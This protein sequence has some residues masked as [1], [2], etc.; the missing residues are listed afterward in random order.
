MIL[1][2]LEN[3]ILLHHIRGK[4]I[5]KILTEDDLIKSEECGDQLYYKEVSL[6]SRRKPPNLK[7][8]KEAQAKTME[9][10]Y[11]LILS[12][13]AMCEEE[14]NFQIKRRNKSVILKN[15]M[16]MSRWCGVL[17]KLRRVTSSVQL[18]TGDIRMCNG[19]KRGY[20]IISTGGNFNP[21]EIG[22]DVNSRPLAIKRIPKSSNIC[23]SLK[24]LIGPLLG[25]RNTHILQYFAC[26]YK[27]SEL[28]LATPLCEYNISEY[29][30][31]M[32]H[33][34]R[35]PFLSSNTV[36]SQFLSGLRFLHEFKEPIVHG[37]LKPSNIFIDLR[38]NVRIAEF[39]IYKV[40]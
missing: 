14:E 20:Y 17:E 8:Q 1:N 7:L 33:N 22:L 36:A 12:I 23:R 21:V 29:M 24:L 27:E 38:G 3:C 25:V 18:Q 2:Q 34:T 13:A 11:H 4:A 19:E 32:R 30:V 15:A 16:G 28:I 40:S 9:N 37:N 39:G 35:I 5:I 6:L 10:K 31:Y 26:D